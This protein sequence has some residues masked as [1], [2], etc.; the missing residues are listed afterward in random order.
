VRREGAFD[1]RII[2]DDGLVRSEHVVQDRVRQIRCCRGRSYEVHG[3]GVSLRCRF[4][5]DPCF[6]APPDDEEP[7]L[8]A[9]VLHGGHHQRLDPEIE[10]FLRAAA[11]SPMPD[12]REDELAVVPKDFG[13]HGSGFAT[14]QSAVMALDSDAPQ[15]PFV[16]TLFPPKGL[17]ATPT[18]VTNLVHHLIRSKKPS[19]IA[20]QSRPPW[21]WCPNP[22]PPLNSAGLRSSLIAE[23]YWSMASR[24]SW[25]GGH[26][27]HSW[28]SSTRAAES[29]ARTSS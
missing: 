1:R 23:R 29:S 16:S 21:P 11:L 27:T 2:D 19:N 7:S 12:A 8:G 13:R 3:H 24:S 25:A 15:A 9:S 17:N 4:C 20:V 6:L 22:H 26:S 28:P 18:I 10:T 14:R 5:L